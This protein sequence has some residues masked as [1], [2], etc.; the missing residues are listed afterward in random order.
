[1]YINGSFTNLPY[2]LAVRQRECSK[3]AKAHCGFNINRG[4]PSKV[5]LTEGNGGERPFVDQILAVG[6]TGVMGREYQAHRDFDLLQDADKYFVC[7][8]KANITRKII[9]KHSAEDGSYIFYDAWYSL[10]HLVKS[11]PSVLLGLLV[12]KLL[13]PNIMLP[14]IGM[15]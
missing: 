13:E 5:F 7:R 2:P 6:Q 1:L 8:I 3:K 14:R 9:E 12:I 10:V 15:I 11:R 4:I